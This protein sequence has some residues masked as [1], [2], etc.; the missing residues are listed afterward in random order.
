M[1]VLS[2]ILIAC[3]EQCLTSNESYQLLGFYEVYLALVSNEQDAT[4]DDDDSCPTSVS[5]LKSVLH[6]V[7]PSWLI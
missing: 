3:K 7:N 4:D 2:F 6:K 1:H 5:T